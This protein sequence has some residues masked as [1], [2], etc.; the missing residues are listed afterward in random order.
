VIEYHQPI[1]IL[2]LTRELYTLKISLTAPHNEAN[3]PLLMARTTCLAWHTAH[4][5]RPCRPR[6]VSRPVV[7]AILPKMGIIWNAARAVIFSPS[8]YCGLGL[9][10]LTV[11]QGHSRI[12][13]L[14]RYLHSKSLT[15]KLI[16]NQLEYTQLEVGCDMNPLS[17]KYERY[18]SLIL[19]PNWVTASWEYL[20]MC[21][22][23][24]DVT[25]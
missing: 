24:I 12:Q 10:H 7:L 14:I 8:Q 5:L 22:A 16:R 15:G 2:C 21:Q 9:D 25:P 19:C 3:A 11:V 6:S 1:N 13:Y 17:L 4:Q 23:S 20:C 18:E